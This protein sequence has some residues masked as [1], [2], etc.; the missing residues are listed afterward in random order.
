[1]LM[2]FEP[3]DS[4]KD[5]FADDVASKVKNSRV[6]CAARDVLRRGF[7]TKFSDLDAPQQPPS[8]LALIDKFFAALKRQRRSRRLLCSRWIDD[9][10]Q[11]DQRDDGA[12]DEIE[13]D[14][15]TRAHLK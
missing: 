10:C 12:Q 8:K 15:A 7:E 2:K 11:Y 4:R 9:S 3:G 5:P 1:M 6:V 13:P 14:K